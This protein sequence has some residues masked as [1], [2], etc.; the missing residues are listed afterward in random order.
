MSLVGDHQVMGLIGVTFDRYVRPVRDLVRWAG[1]WFAAIVLLSPTPPGGRI[2]AA[3]GWLAGAPRWAPLLLLPPALWL[4]RR[5]VWAALGEYLARGADRPGDPPDELDQAE[6]THQRP[7]SVAAWQGRGFPVVRLALALRALAVCALAAASGWA[8]VLVAREVLAADG[9]LTGYATVVA[10]AVLLSW[11]EALPFLPWRPRRPPAR[12]E[13]KARLARYL[14]R[15]PQESGHA[16]AL[17]YAG[18]KLDRHGLTAWI[19]RL[20]PAPRAAQLAGLLLTALLFTLA[21]APPVD[22]LAAQG[23]LGA[24]YAAGIGLFAAAGWPTGVAVVVLLLVSPLP[25]LW[26]FVRFGALWRL[27]ADAQAE[28]LR[29]ERGPARRSVAAA[30]WRALVRA[31]AGAA[32]LW[33][34]AFVATRT[35][36]APA[37]LVTLTAAGLLVAYPAH[38]LTRRR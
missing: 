11:L 4:L 6:L 35:G 17:L 1:R 33:F 38:Q 22:A 23:R 9:S 20:T 10:A 24:G 27:P 28:V 15:Y 19:A 31:V 7:L 8:S 29:R 32:V 26:A 36:S 5:A 37:G 12:P 25:V 14:A 2:D 13:L 21:P 18:S 34:S 30:A 3:V 16:S